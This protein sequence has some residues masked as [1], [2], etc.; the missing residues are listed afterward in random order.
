[1]KGKLC[2]A[3]LISAAVLVLLLPNRVM[4]YQAWGWDEIRADLID[5]D[6]AEFI[7]EIEPLDEYAFTG[8]TEMEAVLAAGGFTDSTPGSSGGRVGGV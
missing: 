4:A 7:I 3:F 5:G 2:V 6:G 8:V 1:M